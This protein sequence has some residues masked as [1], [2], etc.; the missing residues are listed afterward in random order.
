MSIYYNEK[1]NEIGLGIFYLE[2]YNSFFMQVGKFRATQLEDGW[3]N[4]WILLGEL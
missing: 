3:T 2:M 1:T 4:N